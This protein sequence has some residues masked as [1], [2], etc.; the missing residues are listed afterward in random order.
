MPST[1]NSLKDP[2][3][4]TTGND[5]VGKD[6]AQKRNS[7]ATAARLDLHNVLKWAQH[8]R[9]A[10]ITTLIV[11]VST[12]GLL[13]EGLVAA[14]LVLVRH[15][16]DIVVIVSVAVDFGDTARRLVLAVLIVLAVLVVL[17]V[18]IVLA[19]S[20]VVAV[21]IVIVVLVAL[22]SLAMLVVLAALSAIG[23]LALT[24]IVLALLLVV[25]ILYGIGGGEWRNA[26][27]APWWLLAV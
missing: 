23:V 11:I 8:Q 22:L 9:C 20:V 19:L 17:T 3:V 4:H 12:L 15:A 10:V 24:V 21:L 2:H 6:N 1:Q 18:V 14:P 25:L 27:S 13:A 7:L 5:V 16:D 26:L